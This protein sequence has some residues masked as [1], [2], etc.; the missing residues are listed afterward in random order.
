MLLGM[1]KKT[2]PTRQVESDEPAVIEVR[3]QQSEPATTSILAE[4]IEV[5]VTEISVTD[6][7]EEVLELKRKFESR[8]QSAIDGL[9]VVIEN[10]KNKLVELGYQEPAPQ[11]PEPEWLQPKPAAVPQARTQNKAAKSKGGYRIDPLTQANAVYSRML[12]RFSKSMSKKDATEKARS[13]AENYAAR[14]SV[15]WSGPTK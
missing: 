1:A 7:I 12:A 3:E 2:A 5:S 8:R 13:A 10:A 4:T 14:H 6:D 9:L 11:T 15:K